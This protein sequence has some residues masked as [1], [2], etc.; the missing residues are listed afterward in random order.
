M[1]AASWEQSNSDNIKTDDMCGFRFR[2]VL[3]ISV[4]N[5]FTSGR[6]V[7]QEETEAELTAW[8]RIK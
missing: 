8:T 6:D 4:K 1:S 7:F 5:I 3:L 2:R